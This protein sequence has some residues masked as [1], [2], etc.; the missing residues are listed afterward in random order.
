ME[1]EFSA[2]V[3]V[4]RT[5]LEKA[6]APFSNFKVGAA[7]RTRKG[8]IYTGC[9][10][11]V[12][13]YGLTLCAERL[14]I[15]KAL[16]EGEKE[17]EAIAIVT[18]TQRPCPPCG[19]CRQVLW[20]FASNMKIIMANLDGKCTLTTVKELFPHPFDRSRLRT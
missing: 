13:S 8:K 5:A 4:A 3:S 14:A 15:F 19:A 11:E 16:S 20:E 7:L 2:L 12:S 18:N 9:N 10:I 17:F 1:V 6:H